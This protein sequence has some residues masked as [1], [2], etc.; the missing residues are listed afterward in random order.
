MRLLAIVVLLTGCMS[1]ARDPMQV[2]TAIQRVHPDHLGGRC[3]DECTD[4]EYADR[5][6]HMRVRVARGMR[7]QRPRGARRGAA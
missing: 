6:L 2:F 1:V 5:Q 3:D 7:P 4:R